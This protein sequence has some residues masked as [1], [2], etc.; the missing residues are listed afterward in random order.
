MAVVWDVAR[1]T[2]L[3]PADRRELLQGFD[4][5]LG[6]D[7]ANAQPEKEAQESDPRIDALVAEREQARR[8]KDWGGA[9]RIRDELRAEGVVIE[10]TPAGST[11]RRE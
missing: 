2:E 11:W 4:Q 6:L 9:D 5:V 8:S 1:S 10:D 7:L 3:S